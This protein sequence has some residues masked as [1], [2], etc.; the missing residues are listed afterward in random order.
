MRVERKIKGSKGEEEGQKR[1][2]GHKKNEE[3]RKTCFKKSSQTILSFES[4]TVS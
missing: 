3:N 1:I 4:T 2:K